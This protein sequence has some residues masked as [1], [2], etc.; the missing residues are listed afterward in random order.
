MLAQP[1][2]CVTDVE[3]ASRWFQQTPGF[4][5]AH[6]GPDYEQLTSEGVMV[7]QLH[8][9]NAHAHPFL[10][11]PSMKPWGH[12]TVLWFLS[13]AVDQAYERA[14]RAGAEVL[15]ALHLNPRAQH[16]EFWLREPNGYV[17]VV[18][19]PPTAAHADPADPLRTKD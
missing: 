18:A 11:D 6:G 15:E 3:R 8:R 17:V 19:G 14:V 9:W 5:S 13:P 16:L 12:G 10:G 7:L 4:A 2:I 1:L